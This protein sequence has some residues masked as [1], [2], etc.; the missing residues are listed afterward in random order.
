MIFQK[1]AKRIIELETFI[2]NKIRSSLTL[3]ILQN[4][5]FF[6]ENMIPWN[7]GKEVDY[8]ANRAL[9]LIVKKID[10][11]WLLFCMTIQ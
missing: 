6:K 5:S 3:L 11:N 9:K 2:E 1:V 7:K 8:D 4:P 10:Y